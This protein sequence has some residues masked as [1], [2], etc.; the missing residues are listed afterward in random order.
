MVPGLKDEQK[1]HYS[2]Q[3][4]I[5]TTLCLL[6]LQQDIAITEASDQGAALERQQIFSDYHGNHK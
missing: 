4:R 1:T 3:K 2:L 5:G 6:L